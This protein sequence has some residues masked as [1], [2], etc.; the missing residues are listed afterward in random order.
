M[1]SKGVQQIVYFD[2]Y[3][4]KYIY[5]ERNRKLFKKKKDK[6]NFFLKTSIS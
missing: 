1:I 4:Y 3:K 5:R 2:K 6:I